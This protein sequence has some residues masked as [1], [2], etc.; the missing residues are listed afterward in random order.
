MSRAR[1]IRLPNGS[2]VPLST[3]RR[4]IAEQRPEPIEQPTLFELHTDARPLGERTAA[5]RYAA[6][7]LFS[8]LPTATPTLG[9]E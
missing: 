6:P 1:L 3:I 5:E 8:C 9:K 4:L 2:T 7:S